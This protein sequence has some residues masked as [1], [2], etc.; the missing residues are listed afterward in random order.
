MF[1][2]KT[3]APRN[4]PPTCPWSARLQEEPIVALPKLQPLVA[5]TAT[6]S[7][8]SDVDEGDSNNYK[9]LEDQFGPMVRRWR[10]TGA[11][12]GPKQNN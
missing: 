8:T 3:K 6:A 11:Y 9:H 10:S 2:V 5:C 1:N 4:P 12:L 7:D